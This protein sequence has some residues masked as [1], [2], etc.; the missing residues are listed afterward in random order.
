MLNY[1]IVRL[2]PSDKDRVIAFLV[3]FF[4]HD[5]PLNIAVGL[6]QDGQRC[7]EL[8]DYCTTPLAQGKTNL[9]RRP[10]PS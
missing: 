6:M 4:F 7:I 3:K 5:E 1:S 2:S 10:F 8:E 9:P